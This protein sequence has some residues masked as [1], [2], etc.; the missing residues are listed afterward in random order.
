MEDDLEDSV[1]V[2]FPAK[3]GGDT[4]PQA[5]KPYGIPLSCCEQRESRWINV[6]TLASSTSGSGKPFAGIVAII[7]LEAGS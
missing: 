2:F 7:R 4:L 3:T 5:C 6:H 1:D